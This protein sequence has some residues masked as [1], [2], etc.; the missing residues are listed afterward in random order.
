MRIITF[1]SGREPRPPES[2]AAEL[3]AALKGE[4]TGSVAASWR[5]LREDV[6]ALAPP[7]APEVE[8]ELRARI[9]ARTGRRRPG[10]DFSWRVVGARTVGPRRPP[11]TT[12]EPTRPDTLARRPQRASFPRHRRLAAAGTLTV[13]CAIAAAVI[14][15]GPRQAA[16]N[17]QFSPNAKPEIANAGRAA[18]R[19]DLKGAASPAVTSSTA[20]SPAT[21]GGGEAAPGGPAAAPGRVQQLAASISLAPTPADVQATADRVARLTVTD[22]GFVESS[23]V[24]VQHGSAGEANMTLRLPSARLAAALASLGQLA[25]VRSE[26]QSLQDITGAYDAASRRLA[27]AT[28]ERQALLRALSRAVTQGQIDS[29]HERLAQARSAIAQAR[30]SLQA[31]SQ[32]AST[33][34]VEVTVVG[35]GHASSEGL[36]LKRGLHDAEAVLTVILDVLLVLVATIVPLALV[37]AGLATGLRAWRRYHRERALDAA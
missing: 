10:K 18:S 21:A 31:V 32:R 13:A 16:V 19:P 37:L 3:E 12:G 29:F 6:R 28:A 20:A 30:S 14:V 11:V 17:T 15:A 35:N 4:R 5:E 34:E 1:P 23:H 25:P 7:M 27:D 36:T 22:G 9:A 8:H 24:Q 26:S 2:W 33:A